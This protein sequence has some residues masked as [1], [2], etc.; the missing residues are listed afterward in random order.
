[1]KTDKHN[2]PLAELSP[3]TAFTMWIF[4]FLKW[5]SAMKWLSFLLPLLRPRS[6][7]NTQEVESREFMRRRSRA[8]DIYVLCWV[9]LELALVIISCLFPSVLATPLPSAILASLRIIEIIQ[10]TVNATLFDILSGRLDNRA[11]STARMMV[12]AGINF[13]E[14][15]LCFGVIYS[16]DVKLLHG[17]GQAAAA[18]YFSVITQL[19]IG[20][21]SDLYPTGWIKLVSAAQGIAGVLF[22]VLVFARFVAA[23]RPVSG[24]F[25]ER[26]NS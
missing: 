7:L 16:T 2:S 3:L 18:F 26:R 12:L 23:L 10:V 20:Y 11:A 9:F 6:A 4:G 22:V 1:M 8:I 19:T 21:Y 15:L 13:I 24:L 14:L 25:D 17:A 5:I